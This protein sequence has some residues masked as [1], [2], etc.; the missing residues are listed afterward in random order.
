[1]QEYLSREGKGVATLGLIPPRVPKQK[2]TPFADIRRF[3]ICLY[4]FNMYKRLC[5]V[6][7]IPCICLYS[8]LIRLRKNIEAQ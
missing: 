7:Y 5:G 1:M 3:Y 4:N 2:L 6:I 8:L